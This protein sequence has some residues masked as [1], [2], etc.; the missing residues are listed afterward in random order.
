MTVKE[1]ITRLQAL[2]NQDAEVVLEDSILTLAV[3]VNDVREKS[4][5]ENGAVDLCGWTLPNSPVTDW[6]D[7]EEEEDE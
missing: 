6:D 5:W 1:L 4:E 7:E 2:K 3:K